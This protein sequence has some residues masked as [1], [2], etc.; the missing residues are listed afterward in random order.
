MAR[1]PILPGFPPLHSPRACSAGGD[2][3]APPCAGGRSPQTDGT[4]AYELTAQQASAIPVLIAV[5]HAGRCYPP[6]LLE[7]MRL[8]AQAALRLEDRHVDALARTVAAATGASLLIARSPRALI[9]L[10]RA[11]DDVDWEM[12][13]PSGHAPLSPQRPAASRRVR[14]GLGLIPRRLPGMGELW[15]RR[16]DEDE[17]RERIAT[18]H[19][20]YH[21]AL[22]GEL[23][24]LRARWGV[25]MLIDLHSMPPLEPQ[26]SGPSPTFVLGDRFGASCSGALIA[27]AFEWFGRAGAAAAHNRPYAGGYVLERHADPARGIHAFQLEVDRARYLDSRLTEL[28]QGFS[29]VV[30]L[31]AG[32]VTSL[33]GDVAAL[34]RPN[35]RE[36]WQEAAE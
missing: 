19:E 10:N 22:A 18:V 29:E 16:I 11:A 30:A 33:A 35:R 15:R 13:A 4:P 36:T 26:G 14:S 20:P 6:A 32:L 31:I 21:A 7:R 12:V 17:L 25:A 24:R 5:P 9:D 23:A 28:G 27:G 2:Q 8:P 3:A 34:G 1:R